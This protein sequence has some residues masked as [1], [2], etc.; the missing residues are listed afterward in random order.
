MWDLIVKTIWLPQSLW[1]F[2]N[3][4]SHKNLSSHWIFLVIRGWKIRIIAR[5]FTYHKR[6]FFLD[7]TFYKLKHFQDRRSK[8]RRIYEGWRCNR[9][10]SLL[11]WITPQVVDGREKLARSKF[12]YISHLSFVALR[13]FFARDFFSFCG[14]KFEAIN[15]PHRKGKKQINFFSIH[16]AHCLIELDPIRS[17]KKKKC[18]ERSFKINVFF[19]R[20]PN[21]FVQFFFFLFY[22]SPTSVE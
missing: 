21:P 9:K 1:Y 12:I 18:V 7:T 11:V 5:L 14:R 3:W 17:P 20:N 15:K 6:R 8:T 2:S 22:H 16:N 19:L 10:S 4:T 13:G